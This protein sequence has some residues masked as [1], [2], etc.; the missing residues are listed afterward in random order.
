LEKHCLP[1]MMGHF[2][3]ALHLLVPQIEDMVR[4]HLKVRG[5][6]TTTLDSKGIETENALGTLMES[7]ETNQVFGEDMAFEFKALL[8]D[9]FGH[10][11]RNELAHGLL[12]YEAC[13][14]A[15]AVYAWWLGL[16][17]MLFAPDRIISELAETTEGDTDAVGYEK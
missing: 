9:P 12:D 13:E 2:V 4:W 15:Y 10:N 6:K 17:I 14:S 1:D 5:V 16:R 3:S 11:L 7:Y 8:C